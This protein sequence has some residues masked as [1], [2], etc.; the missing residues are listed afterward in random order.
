MN[1]RRTPSPGRGAR[2]RPAL[3][4]LLLAPLTAL[5]AAMPVPVHLQAAIFKKIFSYDRSLASGNA[6]VLVV[7]PDGAPGQRDE[8]VRAFTENGI[9]AS[10]TRAADVRKDIGGATVVYLLPGVDA[11]AIAPLCASGKVLSVT[12]DSAIYQGGG[13][14]VAIGIAEGKPKIMV[15]LKRLRADGHELSGELLKLAQ[16]TE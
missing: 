10:A 8:V 4:A 15:N 11:G 6:K 9:K 2:R 16:V 3:L 1:I 14:A 7:Q 5:V 13:A 12:G